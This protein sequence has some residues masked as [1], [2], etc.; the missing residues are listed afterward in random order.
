MKCGIRKG[1]KATGLWNKMLGSD[2]I[3]QAHHAARKS[4]LIVRQR[5]RE[6]ESERL[7]AWTKNNL[8]AKMQPIYLLI[9][10]AIQ[11]SVSFASIDKS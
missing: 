9:S 1:D 7:V 5:E 11:T 4:H 8:N 6:S 3:H 10:L 2:L